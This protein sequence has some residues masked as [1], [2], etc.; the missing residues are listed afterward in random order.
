MSGFYVFY[1]GKEP[2]SIEPDADA[3]TAIVTFADGTTQVVPLCDI[4][5]DGASR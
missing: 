3:G 1:Q 2:V 5:L 4:D